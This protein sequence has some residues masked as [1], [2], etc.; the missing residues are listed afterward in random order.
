MRVS[1]VCAAW[2]VS[3]AVLT[4]P[5]V[6][7]LG[8]TPDLDVQAAEE[9]PR[10]EQSDPTPVEYLRYGS[11]KEELKFLTSDVVVL[12]TVEWGGLKRFPPESDDSVWGVE[13]VLVVEE[14]LKGPCGE[15]VTFYAWP[16]PMQGARYHEGERILVTLVLRGRGDTRA[17]LGRQERDKYLIDA[18]NTVVRTGLPLDDLLA[19]VRELVAPRTATKLF[20]ASDFVVVGEV[21]AIECGDADEPEREEASVRVAHWL[22]GSSDRTHLTVQVPRPT[23]GQ[24]LIDYVLLRPGEAVLLFLRED[25]QGGCA[26]VGG[27]DGKYRMS[28]ATAAQAIRELGLAQSVEH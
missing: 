8:V 21:A 10:A 26:V 6:A 1:S 17:L 24:L 18:T 25:E 28:D 20:E 13:V 16:P 3:A 15:R 19:Q 12:G 22:K 5:P 23:R 2:L 14:C 7:A 9:T 4:V 27:H 11:T